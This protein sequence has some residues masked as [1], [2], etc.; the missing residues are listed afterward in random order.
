V[1]GRT[2]GSGVLSTEARVREI[3]VSLPTPEAIRV[4][5][6]KLYVKAKEEPTYRFYS[7]YD[8]IWRTDILTHAYRLAKARHGAPGVDGVTFAH[9]EEQG[10]EDW[11]RRLQEDLCSE[12]YQ[13]EAV[14]R[15]YIPKPGG[16]ERPL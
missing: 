3:G 13:P 5:Q 9:V 6:R 12:R 10:L 4:L 14:R 1:E 15:V 16:G 2:P 8:K 11:L 7:L